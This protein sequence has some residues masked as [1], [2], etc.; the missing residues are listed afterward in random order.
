MGSLLGLR[1][2]LMQSAFVIGNGPSLK[3]HI[4]R[5]H[6]EKF[7]ERDE[8]T[9]AMNRIDL[10]YYEDRENGIPG[11]EWRPTHYLFV[12]V[13]PTG[14]DCAEK[15]HWS[16]Y[17]I[18]H[19]ILEGEDCY[20][21]DRFKWEIV[22]KLGPPH[23]PERWTNI[24]WLPLRHCHSCNYRSLNRPEAWHFPHICNYGGTMHWALQLVAM[25]PYNPVYL[26]GC[27]LGIKE[28]DRKNNIDP[29]H[30][31][32]DYMTFS[33]YPLEYQDGT[34]IHMHSIVK[35]EYEARGK[36]IYNAGIG[37]NLEIYDRIDI[38]ELLEA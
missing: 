3:E 32:P 11:T 27:D 28:P 35:K 20:I 13:L 10:L 9:I 8:I 21:N 5:G 37:G 17:V 23:R 18:P 29:N 12:E 25:L 14:N 22:R 16:N 4:K 31:H 2:A 6:F 34:L 30:F 7:M 1:G 24:T 19:H 38:D 26:I 15:D 33:D 36:Q